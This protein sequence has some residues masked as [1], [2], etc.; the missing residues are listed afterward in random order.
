VFTLVSR[1]DCHLCDT[2]HEHLQSYLGVGAPAVK[3]LDVDRDPDLQRRF[4][5]KVPVL[6]LDGEVVCCGKFDRAEVERLT[7]VKA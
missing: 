1:A 2:M 3:V 5:H 6:M 7:R 4:G